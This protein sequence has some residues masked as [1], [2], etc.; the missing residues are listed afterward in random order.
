MEEELQKTEILTKEM[1]IESDN[2]TTNTT[3]TTNTTTNDVPVRRGSVKGRLA[4]LIEERKKI[5]AE[6]VSKIKES[7]GIEGTGSVKN[8]WQEAVANHK[9]HEAKRFEETKETTMSGFRGSHIVGELIKKFNKIFVQKKLAGEKFVRRYSNLRDVA[10]SSGKIGNNNNN[11]NNN[12]N[13][14]NS[15]ET[16]DTNGSLTHNDNNNDNN[17]GNNNG[18]SNNGNENNGNENIKF[19]YFDVRNRPEVTAGAI[20]CI[21]LTDTP[22]AEHIR[23]EAIDNILHPEVGLFSEGDNRP[24][25]EVVSLLYTHEDGTIL[26]TIRMDVLPSHVQDIKSYGHQKVIFYLP[27]TTDQENSNIDRKVGDTLLEFDFDLSP[28]IGWEEFNRRAEESKPIKIDPVAIMKTHNSFF[29]KPINY[30]EIQQQ[31]QS[32]VP[33]PQPPPPPPRHH[34]EEHENENKKQIP[35]PPP[36]PPPPSHHNLNS[37]LSQ[38]DDNLLPE[39]PCGS[40]P[41]L[42]NSESIEIKQNDQVYDIVIDDSDVNQQQDDDNDDDNIQCD[43]VERNEPDDGYLLLTP[44]PNSASKVEVGLSIVSNFVPSL[45]YHES[46]EHRLVPTSVLDSNLD[47]TKFS[48]HLCSKSVNLTFVCPECRTFLCL[49]CSQGGNGVKGT[50]D[51]KQIELNHE[52][53][54][55]PGYATLL[56]ESSILLNQI[57]RFL[58]D[59]PIPILIEGHINAVQTDGTILSDSSKL[60]SVYEPN[61]NGK[62]LSYKRAEK[63]SLYLQSLG[64]S[65]SLLQVEGLGGSRPITRN[66]KELNKN[67]YNFNFIFV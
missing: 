53:L 67:R 1:T 46:H 28:S 57:G 48:C 43:E 59:N 47:L 60:L 18:N 15:N 38:I 44:T 9:D 3:I 16:N 2:S 39:S 27:L 55:K 32:Q 31:N 26:L 49:E 64:I 24:P 22:F 7:R 13:N 45:L 25:I 37:S 29:I 23:K 56:P 17:D 36:P 50:I 51:T 11:S 58:L 6:K 40:E 20:Y 61:C 21:N 35:H 30:N 19:E 12:N 4:E 42:L 41:I 54:F 14:E 66:K 52:I 65:S 33:P 5:D 63:V 8:K 62:M 34:N 10:I